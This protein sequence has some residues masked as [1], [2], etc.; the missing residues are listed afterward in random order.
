MNLN[1]Q[2]G[3]ANRERGPNAGVDVSKAYLDACWGVEHLRV[4]TQLGTTS[5][6]TPSETTP[7][8]IVYVSMAAH[9]LS[10]HELKHLQERAQQRNV[11]Q[12]V[13]GVLLYSEGAFMQYLE[14][15]GLD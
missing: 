6:H 10:L 3:V 14:G 4:T 8:A 1:P 12:D 9:Q 2:G 15:P 5:G 13:T 11:Q 7:F